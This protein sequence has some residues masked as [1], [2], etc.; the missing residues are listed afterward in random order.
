MPPK[1]STPA[2]NKPVINGDAL[3]DAF[4]VLLRYAEF[5]GEK[6]Y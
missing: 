3:D 4:A 2:K 5:S 6:V 1:K